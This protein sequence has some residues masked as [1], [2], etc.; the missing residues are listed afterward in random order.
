M[1]CA[2]SQEKDNTMEPGLPLSSP[3]LTSEDDFIKS[4]P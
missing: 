1:I 3:W 4:I 2:I